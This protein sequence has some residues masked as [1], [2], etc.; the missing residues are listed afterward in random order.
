METIESTKSSVGAAAINEDDPECKA[1]TNG[2]RTIGQ[3][4]ELS[5]SF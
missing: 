2:L 3:L 1:I 5:T 4:V